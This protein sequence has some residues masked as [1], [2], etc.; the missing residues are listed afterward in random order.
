MS[1]IKRGLTRTRRTKPS[2]VEVVMSER[3]L[4]ALG[5]G[6]IAYI[7]VMSSDEAKRVYPSVD[8]LPSGIQLYALH[9]ADG[10][11]IALTDSLQAAMGHA[12]GDDLQIAS[13]N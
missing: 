12:M 7:K 11:P 13:I 1:E 2:T 8:D 5:G 9:A 4:A 10:S 6:Q 3:E